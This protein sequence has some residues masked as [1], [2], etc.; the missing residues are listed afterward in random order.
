[1]C[2]RSEFVID[3]SSKTALVTGGGRGIGKEI[4]M[5]LAKAGCDVAISDIDLDTAQSTAS[6]IEGTGRR[7]LAIKGDVSAV[8]MSRAMFASFLRSSANSTYFE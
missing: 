1:M 6:E 3:L 4:A 2:K 5:R 7:S 8:Q